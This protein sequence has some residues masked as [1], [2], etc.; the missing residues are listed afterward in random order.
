MKLLPKFYADFQL[1]AEVQAYLIAHLEQIAIE[2]SF[3]GKD[4]K[5]I[6]EAKECIDSAFKKL[7]N[8]Y[9]EKKKRKPQSPR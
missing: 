9:G 3:A 1:K 7:D 4:T 6:K 8:M 5:G 2:K